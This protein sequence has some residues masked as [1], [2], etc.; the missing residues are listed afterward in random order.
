MELIVIDENKLKIMLSA[1]DMRHYELR[2]ERMDCA[3]EETRRAFRHIFHDARDRIGFETEGERLFVQLYTSRGG[4]CEIFVTKLGEATVS[5]DQK[6]HPLARLA[7]AGEDALLCRLHDSGKP[8]ETDMIHPADAPIP[9]ND[10]IPAPRGCRE[11]AYTLPDMDTLLSLCRRLHSVGYRGKSAVYIDECRDREEGNIWYLFL[12]VPNLTPQKG[13]DRSPDLPYA[14]AF[15]SE[16]GDAV[17]DIS[18][19]RTYLSE[20][21]HSVCATHAVQTLA[22]L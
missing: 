19:A 1:P 21:G 17:S 13:F 4:G 6:D 15:L 22:R 5:G 10:R 9:E 12:E 18:A 14:L 3:D 20:Y 2:A 7:Q 8:K 16:Y 11:I